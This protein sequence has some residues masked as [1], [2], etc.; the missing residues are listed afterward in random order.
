MW[1]SATTDMIITGIGQTLYMTI[2]STVVGYVFGLPLGVM[3]AVF[4]KDGLRPNKAV[5]KVLDVISNI[6]RSIPFLILLIL[7]IPLTRIIVGQSYGSSATVV[8][9]VVAAIPFIG[10]MVES[11]IK[12]VDAGVVEAARSMGASDLRII[13]KVLLLES[14]TSLITGATIAIGTILGYSAMAGSVG[15]GGLGDIAIRYGY[16]R[17]ESQI[18]IVTVIL[19][20]VLVQVFQS[21]GMIIA[22]KLDKRRK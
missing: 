18:M 16:Y 10:R 14:R 21:I 11:S 12:E 15:G 7:I 8:P 13:V 19:L 2:L 6:I 5:Y 4:D 9:L 22:S 17:Y 3:L 20:V 1:T